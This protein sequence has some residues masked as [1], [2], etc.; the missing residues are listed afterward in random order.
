MP[1]DWLDSIQKKLTEKKLTIG[2][3]DETRT[4]ICDILFVNTYCRIP[5]FISAKESKNH[6]TIF[7]PSNP[8]FLLYRWFGRDSKDSNSPK[9][10]SIQSLKSAPASPV[11]GGFQNIFSDRTD[12]LSSTDLQY[13]DHSAQ[14]TTKSSPSP[15]TRRRS[16]YPSKVSTIDSLYGTSDNRNSNHVIM[17][18]IE[19]NGSDQRSSRLETPKVPTHVMDGK[20]FTAIDIN[21]RK[22]T[23]NTESPVNYGIQSSMTL[24]SFLKGYRP[25][26]HVT[27]SYSNYHTSYTNEFINRPSIF[28]DSLAS[29]SPATGESV[30][31]YVPPPTTEKSAIIKSTA[32][33]T[34]MYFSGEQVT[35]PIQNPD[36]LESDSSEKSMI[37]ARPYFVV[38]E[39]EYI[40]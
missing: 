40:S 6:G 19:E 32:E 34:Q 21:G 12:S 29:S 1:N 13:T 31:S 16:F 36:I 39:E 3:F 30:I 10:I 5:A 28:A 27:D 20:S 15:E 2:I 7:W 33:S 11:S 22:E 14:A 23:V 24:N 25:E 18:E 38:E 4:F 9:T 35:V 37:A 8:D 17:E 26:S